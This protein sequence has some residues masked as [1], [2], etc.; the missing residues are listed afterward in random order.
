M[1]K[2]LLISLFVFVGCAKQ[3]SQKSVIPTYLPMIGNLQETI[4]EYAN[5]NISDSS[6]CGK[7]I[8][9]K[10]DSGKTMSR[11]YFA[12]GGEECYGSLYV[13]VIDKKDRRVV[14]EYLCCGS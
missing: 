10:E 1:V 9:V 2:Y 5:R 11:Y 8:I 3:H 6:S 4:L 14:Q 12:K 7:Y 13:I